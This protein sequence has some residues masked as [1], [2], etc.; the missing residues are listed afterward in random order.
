[1]R[2]NRLDGHVIPHL[3]RPGAPTVVERFFDDS[4]IA[5][6]ICVTTYDFMSLAPMVVGTD[7]IATM[8][9]RLALDSQRRLPVRLLAPPIAIPPL[10]LCMQWHAYQT[11]DPA[12]RWL[13][14]QIAQV[15][16][17]A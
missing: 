10:R 1:M 4:G 11:S 15:A 5:R 3:G 8:Q 12:H 2:F 17:E 16:A 7:L 14:E 9:T 13:R 6:N